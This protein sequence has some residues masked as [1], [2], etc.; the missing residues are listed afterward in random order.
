MLIAVFDGKH[1]VP[2]VGR[3][4][5]GNFFGPFHCE[6][7]RASQEFLE[8]KRFDLSFVFQ[9]IRIEMD[10]G[11]SASLVHGENRKSRARYPPLNTQP[12]RETLDKSRFSDSHVAMQRK[13]RFERESH[14]QF[15]RQSAGLLGR[16]GRD[17]L[18]EFFN[19]GHGVLGAIVIKP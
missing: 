1:Q 8:K 11:S 17:S 4:P 15:G 3:Q 13:R 7:I 2:R 19:N 9:S 6:A 18:P 5:F 14:R 12:L 10:Q 16:I